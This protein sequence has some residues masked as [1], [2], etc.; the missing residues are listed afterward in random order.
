MKIRQPKTGYVL[1]WESLLI[2]EGFIYGKTKTGLFIAEPRITSNMRVMSLQFYN[3]KSKRKISQSKVSEDENNE[4]IREIVEEYK[5]GAI[6]LKVGFT[7]EESRKWEER[8]ESNK[9]SRETKEIERAVGNYSKSH[10]KEQRV[11]V[12]SD[13]NEKT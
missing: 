6:E 7:P 4:I 2:P 11:R 10:R 1:G 12:R 3:K 13:W 5:A 8:W 9:K